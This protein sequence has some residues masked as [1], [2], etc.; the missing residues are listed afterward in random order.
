MRARAPPREKDKSFACR[1]SHSSEKFGPAA[2]HSTQTA[3]T[4]QPDTHTS[5]H[6]HTMHPSTVT[7]AVGALE[8][9]ARAGGA[10]GAAALR[11]HLSPAVAALSV[12]RE[13]RVVWDEW[14]V[15]R[16]CE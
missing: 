4:T 5:T 1:Q 9:A 3:H 2:R 15:W 12:I 7:L 16:V 13:R 6:T 14:A 10:A 8:A 11:A